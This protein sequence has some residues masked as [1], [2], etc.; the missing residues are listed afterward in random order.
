MVKLEEYKIGEEILKI[1]SRLPYR[2]ECRMEELIIEM[3]EGMQGKISDFE[4]MDFSDMDLSQLKGFN[5]SKKTV[6]NDFL[7]IN[8]VISPKITEADLDNYDYYLNDRFKEIGDYLF[9]KYI[10]QYS[11][12]VTVKKKLTT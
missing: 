3:A 12:K 8:A 10:G 6:I 5:M 2:L 9:N 4:D 1:F 7:L 11:E